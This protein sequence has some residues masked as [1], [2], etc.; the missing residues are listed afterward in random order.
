M[1]VLSV[2]AGVLIVLVQL[3]MCEP[4]PP[5]ASI[6]VAAGHARIANLPL[7]ALSVVKGLVGQVA[8]RPVEW[9][10]VLQL[11]ACS[12]GALARV[13]RLLGREHDLMAVVAL[14]VKR[15][16]LLALDSFHAEQII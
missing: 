1:Q 3:I 6:R 11:A 7:L 14:G 15:V 12:L 16:R 4:L 13:H 10:V 8:A 2:S 9:P 5:L